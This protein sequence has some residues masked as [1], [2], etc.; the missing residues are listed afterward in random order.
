MESSD[1]NNGLKFHIYDQQKFLIP[2][3][4]ANVSELSLFLKIIVV[5]LTSKL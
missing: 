1:E 2:D 5:Y 3:L 4:S